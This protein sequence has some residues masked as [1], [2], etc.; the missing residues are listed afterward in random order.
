MHC[1]RE[2]SKPNRGFE[3]TLE[4]ILYFV[5]VLCKQQSEMSMFYILWETGTMTT[6]V[7]YISFWN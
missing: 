3:H 6:N 5:A 1:I 2:V 4:I 7:L